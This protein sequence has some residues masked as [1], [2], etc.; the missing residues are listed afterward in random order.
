MIIASAEQALKVRVAVGIKLSVAV[1][2]RW[3][4]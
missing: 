1:F 2:V 3:Q 4:L